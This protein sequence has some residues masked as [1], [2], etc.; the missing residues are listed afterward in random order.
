MDPKNK[1]S[2]LFQAQ[3]E[4]LEP[5]LVFAPSLD[6]SNRKGFT[7]IIKSL[8]DDILQMSSLIGRIDPRQK[9]SYEV[10]IVNNEDITEM[11]DD[12]LSGIEK[13]T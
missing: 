8:I 6:P 10:D 5:D 4:L 13:V 3:L 11:R 9:E 7:A 2:P 1:L 12:I